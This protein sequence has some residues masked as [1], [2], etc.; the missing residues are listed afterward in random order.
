MARRRGLRRPAS[1]HRTPAMES[2]G[3]IRPPIRIEICL[4]LKKAQE[5]GGGVGS[6]E[7]SRGLEAQHA[8]FQW[9]SGSSAQSFA[10][11]FVTNDVTNVSI[12]GIVAPV[13]AN[14]FFLTPFG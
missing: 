12:D 5:T 7:Y 6:I 13:S 8:M 14:N 10:V 3:S 9:T 2:K 4:S 1:S 11:G